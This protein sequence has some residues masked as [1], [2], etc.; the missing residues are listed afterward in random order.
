MK[1]VTFKE[2]NMK[3]VAPADQ[4]EV[5]DL[6]AFVGNDQEGSPVIISKWE[7]SEEEV[8]QIVKNKLIYLVVAG[9]GM[10]PLSMHTETVFSPIIQEEKPEG[11]IITL[12]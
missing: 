4:P 1:P 10:P 2:A 9:Q 12:K 11:K 7:L 5:G 8:K 3:F 6:P